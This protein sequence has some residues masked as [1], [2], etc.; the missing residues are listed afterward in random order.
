LYRKKY[1]EKLIPVEECVKKI[2]LFLQYQHVNNE[3]SERAVLYEARTRHTELV[4]ISSILADLSPKL[5]PGLQSKRLVTK[6]LICG[7]AQVVC[8]VHHF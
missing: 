5:N 6:D 1:A 8:T 7:T 4:Q 2:L 3:F